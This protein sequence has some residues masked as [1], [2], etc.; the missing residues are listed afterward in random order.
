MSHLWRGH[1][2]TPHQQDLPF[3][4]G[5][6]RRGQLTQA[7]LLIGMLRAARVKREPLH[8]PDIMKA[9]IAQHGARFKEIREQG[10]EIENE[11]ERTAEGVVLSRYWLR[12]DPELDGGA[13]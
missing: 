11:M 12:H 2:A 6:R 9:G 3:G 13:E 1:A 4:K 8:L 7:D 5:T 10:F